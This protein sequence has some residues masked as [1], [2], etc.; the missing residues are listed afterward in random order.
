MTKVATK[1]PRMRN[2]PQRAKM[3]SASGH[4]GCAGCASTTCAERHWHAFAG[5]FAAGAEPHTEVSSDGA[6]VSPLLAARGRY[7][8][9]AAA[10]GRHRRAF[11][12]RPS[13][14][15][16]TVLAGMVGEPPQSK[17]I[18]SASTWATS[19]TARRRRPNW[20]DRGKGSSLRGQAEDRDE[21]H[22]AAF[23]RKACRPV[24]GCRLRLI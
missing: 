4:V 17:R 12:C 6:R 1:T 21:R 14:T 11:R 13:P 23:P 20:F 2:A 9:P 3:L 19:N 8:Y 5:P 18:G 7:L 15:N 16:T 10:R 22:P 24:Q